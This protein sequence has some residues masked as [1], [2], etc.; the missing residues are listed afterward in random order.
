MFENPVYILFAIWKRNE[1][2]WT[3][4]NLSKNIW[5]KIFNGIDWWNIDRRE[6]ALQWW[7]IRWLTGQLNTCYLLCCRL[8]Q[9]N[10]SAYERNQL[11]SEELI[12][13]RKTSAILRNEL[14][15]VNALN[16]GSSNRYETSRLESMLQR[17]EQR[18][19]DLEELEVELREK[20]SGLRFAFQTLYWFWTYIIMT[21][22]CIIPSRPMINHTRNSEVPSQKQILISEVTEIFGP[23]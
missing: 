10:S 19:F 18:V 14:D 21:S 13:E 3:K 1:Y 17:Y 20:I 8:E 2:L 22:G 11:L 12:Q 23:T 4:P 6:I 15:Q 16:A 9:Q 5:Y 7:Y